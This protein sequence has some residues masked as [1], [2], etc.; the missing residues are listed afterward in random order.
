MVLQ[1]ALDVAHAR[2]LDAER[3]IARLNEKL[4]AATERI[5]E[6]ERAVMRARRAAAEAAYGAQSD[7]YVG[8]R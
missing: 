2:V 8:L 7:A 1:R 6:L 5:D 3:T 4:L